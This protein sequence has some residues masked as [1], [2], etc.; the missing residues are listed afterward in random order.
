MRKP[1][2]FRVIRNGL[3]HV[4]DAAEADLGMNQ[5]YSDLQILA[6][7]FILVSTFG[8]M[9][10]LAIGLVALIVTGFIKAPL[11]TAVGLVGFIIVVCLGGIIALGRKGFPGEDL[12]DA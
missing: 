11:Y 5:G 3:N 4:P 7:R 1:H 10:A 2:P 9:A 8:L 6:A 12:P